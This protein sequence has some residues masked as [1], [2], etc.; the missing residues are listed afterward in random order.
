[1]RASRD[2][3]LYR[4]KLAIVPDKQQA[5]A[6]T[7][8]VWHKRLAHM[9]KDLI[10]KMAN[11]K[12]VMGLSISTSSSISTS[13]KTD[14]KIVYSTSVVVHPIKVAHLTRQQDQAKVSMQT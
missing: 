13:T 11:D 9:P 6:A 7:I 8:D 3:G 1:M 14:A 10:T 4:I 5:F 12:V 2:R